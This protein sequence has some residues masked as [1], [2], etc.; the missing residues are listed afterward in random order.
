MPSK[1][2]VFTKLLPCLIYQQASKQASRASGRKTSQ[3][4][5]QNVL[6]DARYVGST[7][8]EGIIGYAYNRRERQDCDVKC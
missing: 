2:R 8:S 4:C 5:G 1:L 6:D 3:S 7:R